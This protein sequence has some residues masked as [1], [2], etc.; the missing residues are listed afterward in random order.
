MQ[1]TKSTFQ[2]ALHPSLVLSNHQI[3][4]LT[5]PHETFLPMRSQSQTVA[6][7]SVL[8]TTSRPTCPRFTSQPRH[9]R[10]NQCPPPLAVW[11]A[12]DGNCHRIGSSNC[13]HCR[14]SRR[15]RHSCWPCTKPS[16]PLPRSAP[17]RASRRRRLRRLS[18]RRSG[19]RP[20]LLLRR[21]HL[22]A[23]SACLPASFPP[24]PSCCLPPRPPGARR[25]HSSPASS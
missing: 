18:N 9:A 11:T 22:P 24:L 14:L 5:G 20:A 4:G 2:I 1:V 15:M 8:Q 12:C 19:A 6:T 16:S 7:S 13:R 23:P 17:S 10:P 3:H 21:R 25:R